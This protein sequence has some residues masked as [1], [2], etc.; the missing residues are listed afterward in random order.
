MVLEPLLR[1]LV[2]GNK[3]VGLP[4]VMSRYDTPLTPFVP[5]ALLQ[6]VDSIE[7][8]RYDWFDVKL[9]RNHNYYQLT[10]IIASRGCRWSK[11]TFCAERFFWRVRTPTKVVDE[12]EWLAE[13][14]CDLFMFNESDLNGRPEVM[15]A[16]CEEII[17]RQ[18]K[19][20]LT[21]QLRIHKRSN[22]AFFDTL[23]A[24]GFVSLRFGVD[25]WSKNTLRLQVK[26]YTVQMIIDNLKACSRAR[27][28]CEVNIVVG[29]PGETEE[30]IDESIELL[31]AN[32]NYIGR[33]ANINPL[34]LTTGSMYWGDLEKY[35]IHLRGKKEEIFKHHPVY[36]PAPLWYSTDPYIDEKIRQQRF[37]KFVVNLYENGV[38]LGP[39]AEHVYQRVKEGKDPS[40]GITD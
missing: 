39:F 14:G 36:V 26:G 16:I 13:Q 38:P 18:L 27:I 8:P 28:S 17:R 7:I 34:I 22:Q 31:I 33:V 32:K 23:R 9:Y 21:G 25:A 37:E 11:C 4:G 1:E 5:G 19:V 10:P 29:V 3:P 30:D 35:N 2:K 15:L 6:E 20:R 24:A 12:I 40:R